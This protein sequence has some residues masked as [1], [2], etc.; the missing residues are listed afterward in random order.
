MCFAGFSFSKEGWRVHSMKRGAS[1]VLDVCEKT[2]E[3]QKTIRGSW[4]QLKGSFNAK[5]LTLHT[6]C[7]CY[8]HSS[9]F[10]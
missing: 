9:Q 3:Y 6:T 2:Q 5:G 1:L 4:F 8:R 7:R 10:E